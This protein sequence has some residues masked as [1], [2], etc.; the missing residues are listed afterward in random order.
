[1]RSP[2]QVLNNLSQHSKISSYKFERLYRN[3]FNEQ[4]FYVAYQRIYAKQ[5]NMTP[6]TDGQTIDQMSIQRISSLIDKIKDETYKPF[7]AKRVYIPKKNGG[8]RPLGIPSFEDKLVQ[9]VV[10]MLLEAIYEGSFERTSHG[11]RPFKSC[12]TALKDI[13]INFKGAKWFIEGDIKGFFDN[14]DHN[15][16]IGILKE[17]ISDERFLRL[18]RKFLNAGYME[19]WRFNKTL[20]GT[21][22][23]GIISPILANIY[24]DK[25]DKYIKKY[26]ES[27]DK[28]VKRRTN[29][30]Y[31]KYRNHMSLLQRYLKADI[32]EA[33]RDELI[34]ELKATRAEMLKIPFGLGMDEKYKRMKYV[35]YADD[36][37]IGVIGSKAECE[38]IKADIT[39]FM[40]SKL[41]LEMSQEKTLITHSSKNA[42]FLGYEIH[43][44]KSDLLKTNGNGDKARL[45]T[46][47]VVFKVPVEAVKKKLQLY[48][49]V[50]YK[51]ID[52]REIWWPISRGHLI[53]KNKEVII[54]QFNSEIR[55]F[56]NYYAFAHN[57][58]QMIGSFGYVMKYSFYKT[59]AQKLNSSIRKVCKQFRRG[60]DFVVPYKDA[61]GKEK[62][63]VLYNEGYKRKVASTYAD[64]DNEVETLWVPQ[65][66][67][68]DRLM[69]N[70][71]ELCGCQ[72]KLV[73]HHVRNL[74]KIKAD[75]K[76]NKIMLAK[77]SKTLAV[78]E[79]CNK[80]IQSYG[81]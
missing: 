52:G 70:T 68:I 49:A 15:I 28:G 42:K 23:G 75:T 53:G 21:P 69:S 25:F 1:M 35:R 10:R 38:R 41:K 31:N 76:W 54:A 81:K 71:C 56:Y 34:A 17:R 26:I 33:K 79:N 62:F 66:S 12:H 45:H 74:R 64:I 20:S 30:A 4:M 27:F 22:Q 2:E 46:G 9:E 67:L 29:P 48:K 55:G 47:S 51:N 3:L 18:I 63:I 16:L 58:S 37:L 44:Q 72:G 5:G 32:S 39:E 57:A 77:N 61:K 14:I 73:M 80:L 6:G 43:V 50:E 7:P 78:C 13:Q 60:K 8:K 19:E 11:F 40:A 24:L 59:M 36:F 65:P